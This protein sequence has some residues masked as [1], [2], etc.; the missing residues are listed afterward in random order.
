M[1]KDV[2]S[3]DSFHHIGKRIQCKWSTA[4]CWYSRKGFT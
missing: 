4:V 3:L 2:Q 1:N